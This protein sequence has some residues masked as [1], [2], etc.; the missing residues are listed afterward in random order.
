[1]SFLRLLARERRRLAPR[2]AARRSE[3]P[4]LAP[5]PRLRD[6]A[7]KL[8]R[9]PKKRTKEQLK[10]LWR[11][12]AAILCV[13][14]E[15]YQ[16]DGDRLW[17]ALVLTAVTPMLATVRNRFTGG[18]ADEREGLFLA[19]LSAVI[20]T[21]DPRRKP[22]MIFGILWM[23]TKKRVTPKL[24]KE[25]EWGGVG[26]DVEADEVP[27]ETMPA[28]EEYLLVD[29]ASQANGGEMVRAHVPVDVLARTRRQIEA[30]VGREFG[31]L[32]ADD[33]RSLYEHLS[34]LKK[35][36]KH[37]EGKTVPR[38]RRA[39]R[40]MSSVPPESGTHLRDGAP[41]VGVTA[42]ADADLDAADE[43]NADVDLDA[44]TASAA[45]EVG[46]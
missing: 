30:Y 13:L 1:M 36:C 5:Y 4:V 14:L 42:A 32:P 17:Q 21:I 37:L 41:L 46:S 40:A 38:A 23:K 33:Q 31:C 27:D 29:I 26:L 3:H 39:R 19:G 10:V 9:T 45:G 28:P 2:Y 44:E 12:R 6:L 16:Q 8:T 7:R 24:R 34:A 22:E 18:D 20:K 43:V 11:E 15:A 35:R 25:H